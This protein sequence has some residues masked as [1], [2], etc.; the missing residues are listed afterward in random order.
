MPL[1]ARFLSDVINDEP[2]AAPIGTPSHGGGWEA[3]PSTSLQALSLS[4]RK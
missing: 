1:A 4:N 2:L 3:V